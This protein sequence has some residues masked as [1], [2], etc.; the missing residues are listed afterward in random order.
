[1]L[2]FSVLMLLVGWQNGFLAYKMF[3]QNSSYKFTFWGPI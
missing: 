1:M 2:R 3:C